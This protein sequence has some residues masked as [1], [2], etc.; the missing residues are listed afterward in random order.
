M[1]R[2]WAPLCAALLAIISAGA[3][4]KGATTDGGDAGPTGPTKMTVKWTFTGKP[5]S[6]A[7]CSAHMAE[8]VF[9]NLSGTIDPELHK[10]DTVACSKGT[11]DLGS[12]LIEK[13]GQPYVEASLLDAKGVTVTLVGQLVN[14]T[15]GATE[16]VLDF[17]P[18]MNVGGAGTS[19]SSSTSASSA[20]STSGMGGTGGMMGTGGATTTTSTGTGGKGTGGAGGA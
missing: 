19:S 8:E 6:A 4:G 12:P 5:A 13:L 15:P 11:A 9:V 7:E 10:S 1:T 14:P 18:A 16:V 20:A 17:F 2:G 3:C